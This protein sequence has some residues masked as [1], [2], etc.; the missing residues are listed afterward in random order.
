MKETLEF[1]S[2]KYWEPLESHILV[3]REVD[4]GFINSLSESDN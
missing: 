2:V 3:M 1:E 4:V